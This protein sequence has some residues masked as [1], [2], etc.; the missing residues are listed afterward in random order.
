MTV[1]GAARVAVGAIVIMA[2][3]TF[4]QAPSSPAREP[5]DG[6]AAVVERRVVTTSE[7]RAEARLVLLER[8][9]AEAAGGRLDAALEKAVLDSMVAQELLALEARRTGVAV[10]EIDIDKS[11]AGVRAH[12]DDAD[13]ARGFFTRFGVD[14]ELLRG[15]ARRDLAAGVLLEKTLA[16]IKVTD[17][18]A[19][20]YLSEHRDL[21]DRAVAKR[22][23]EKSRRD[24]RFDALM[25]RLSASVEVRVVWHP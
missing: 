16:D 20:A 5:I 19:D 1:L 9:G 23:L 14:E 21:V 13:T 2:S 6:V 7:V 12:F 11:V 15:R 17:E 10:R 8:A 22:S 25:H 3:S 18:E 4:A 24:A